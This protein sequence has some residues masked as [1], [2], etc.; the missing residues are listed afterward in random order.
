MRY[1]ILREIKKKN[2]LPCAADYGLSQVEFENFIFFLVNN[3]YLERVL[4]VNDYFSLNPTRLTVKGLYLLEQ[5]NQYEDTYPE[6]KDILSWV[7]C[8]KELYSNDA[9]EK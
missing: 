6:R 7:K 3:G 5:N 1:S 8:E 9:E 4:K 2:F